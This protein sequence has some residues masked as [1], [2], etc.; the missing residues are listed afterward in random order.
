MSIHL[1]IINNEKLREIYGD[2]PVSVAFSRA[3]DVL[4]TAVKGIAEIITVAGILTS[5]LRM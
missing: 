4:A 3:D 1:L 2:Q 5:I